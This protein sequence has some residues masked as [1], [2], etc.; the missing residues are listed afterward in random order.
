[1][2]HLYATSNISTNGAL[3]INNNPVVV[4]SITVPPG[5]YQMFAKASLRNTDN[6]NF[7]PAQCALSAGDPSAAIDQVQSTL[8]PA[9]NAAISLQAF[10]TFSGTTSITLLCQ[11]ISGDAHNTQLSAL[12]VAAI[13]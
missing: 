10:A 13:N 6:S 3:L 2:T 7:F 4:A 11:T 1:M 12:A 8:A 9:D 5:I